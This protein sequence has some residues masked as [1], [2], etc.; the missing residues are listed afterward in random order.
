MEYT[1]TVDSEKTETTYLGKIKL[2]KEP[3]IEEFNHKNVIMQ[4][5]KLKCVDW[6]LN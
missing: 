1:Y 2:N 6:Y 4:G 3:K 5:S